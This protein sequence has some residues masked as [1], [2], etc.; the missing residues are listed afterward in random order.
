[1]SKTFQLSIILSIETSKYSYLNVTIK[2]SRTHHEAQLGLN[3]LYQQESPI[4][5]NAS[6]M[7]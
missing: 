6:S 3:D 1:M 2:S 4:K 5:N 7:M